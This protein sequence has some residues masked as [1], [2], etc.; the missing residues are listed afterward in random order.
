MNQLQM[1]FNNYCSGKTR[2]NYFKQYSVIF[3]LTGFSL[4]NTSFA[5]TSALYFNGEDDY[6][7]VDI[8]LPADYTFEFYM[9]FH[10]LSL[11]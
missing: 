7:T 10:N 1:T 11:G 3:S 9:K 6:A 2:N 4:V 5:Q 8:D